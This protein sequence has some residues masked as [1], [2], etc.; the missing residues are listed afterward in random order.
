MNEFERDVQSKRNDLID[1]VV[2][3]VVPFAFFTIIMAV[4]TIIEVAGGF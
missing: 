1:S 3:F 2:G 4:A